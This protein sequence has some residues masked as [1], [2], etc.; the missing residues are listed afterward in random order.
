MS[1]GKLVSNL[2][3]SACCWDWN[4]VLRCPMGRSC[5]ALVEERK[6]AAQAARTRALGPEQRDRRWV[7]REGWLY[8]WSGDTFWHIYRPDGTHADDLIED[9]LND[10]SNPDETYGPWRAAPC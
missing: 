10:Y 8:V 1:A 4:C 3:A 2:P 6:A 9:V 7:D 5:L